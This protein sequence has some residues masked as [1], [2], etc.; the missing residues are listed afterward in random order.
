MIEGRKKNDLDIDANDL[1]IVHNRNDRMTIMRNI[2]YSISRQTFYLIIGNLHKLK[3][4][5]EGETETNFSI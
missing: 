4:V 3:K 5:N 2:Y 1:I